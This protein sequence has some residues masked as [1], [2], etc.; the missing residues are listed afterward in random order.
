MLDLRRKATDKHASIT[1]PTKLARALPKLLQRSHPRTKPMCVM[2]RKAKSPKRQEQ[3]N[4][5]RREERL[6]KDP[7]DQPHGK[8]VQSRETSDSEERIRPQTLRYRITPPHERKF[9]ATFA[10]E[11]TARTVWRAPNHRKYQRIVPKA[12]P[13]TL[14][15]RFGRPPASCLSTSGSTST[16]AKPQEPITTPSW[17]WTPPCKFRTGRSQATA[18]KIA[19]PGRLSPRGYP[20]VSKRSPDH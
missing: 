5:Q 17:H 15:R 2:R 8:R 6:T 20:K 1:S 10:A 12:E 13:C 7:S 11:A 9:P 3:A 19:P 14:G 4:H 16:R 18:G